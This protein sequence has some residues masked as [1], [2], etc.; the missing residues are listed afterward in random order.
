MTMVI[1]VDLSGPTNTK[2]TAAACFRLEA[3]GI[4]CVSAGLGY[5]DAA[6]CDLVSSVGAQEPLVI[7]LDAP[8]S[9]QPGGGDRRRDTRL[10]R[11]L[12]EAGLPS[13]TVMAPTM[14]RM[15]Y[16]TLRGVAVARAVGLVAPR[17]RIVEVHPGG[18]MVLR[19][20][21]A[22]A[23]RTMKQH[24]S[25]RRTVVRW[26]TSQGIT[27]LP[28]EGVSDHEVASFACALAAWKWMRGHPVWQAAASLPLH[29][30]DF[31]C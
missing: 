20:A 8:L 25:S 4:V 29:P 28:R 9:Y 13:G 26:L 15:A 24:A 12:V 7:G 3:G 18:A 16:L 11:R 23:V 27:G 19:G 21:P 5:T 17:A 6:L 30:Y 1:G 10:R 14:T 31:V 2:D 22:E